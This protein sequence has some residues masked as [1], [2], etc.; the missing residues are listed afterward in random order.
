VRDWTRTLWPNVAYEDETIVRHG[1]AKPV[2]RNCARTLAR[3]AA[4]A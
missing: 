2:C 4:I 3:L 1:M